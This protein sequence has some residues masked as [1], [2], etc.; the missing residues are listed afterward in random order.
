MS[1]V[2]LCGTDTETNPLH[3]QDKEGLTSGSAQTLGL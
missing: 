3:T 1:D 2:S